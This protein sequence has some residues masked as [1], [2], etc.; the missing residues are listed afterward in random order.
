MIRPA[1]VAGRFYPSDAG[2]LEAQIDQLTSPA[3]QKVS[4]LGCIV[5]HAGYIYSG[6]VAG[7]VYGSIHLPSRF[8]LLGPRHYPQGE[9]FAILS[10]G[11]WQTPLGPANLDSALATELQNA[12]PL[13]REDTV[14][15]APEHSLEVQL[16]FLLRF[17]ADLTFAPVLIATD[18]FDALE[19]LGHAVASVV[20]AQKEPVMI[21]ASSDMNHHESDAVTRVKDHKAIDAIL[22][23][24]ARRLYNTVRREEIS[25]CGYGPAVVMLTAARDLGATRA[26]LVR[27]ATS[28]DVTGDAAD[29]VGYAGITVE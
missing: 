28:A 25:M 17:V 29:V 20:K 13:L 12:F 21:L 24:D 15:H 23:L 16:P 2:S 10:D 26:S 19:A 14:A 1:A 11:A 3:S 18:R 8:I 6:Q 22:A 4:A 27:Y 9:R 5:P 7:A